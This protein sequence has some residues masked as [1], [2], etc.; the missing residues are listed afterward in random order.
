MVGSNPGP[1]TPDTR[2]ASYEHSRTFI[3]GSLISRCPEMPRP[4]GR[5]WLMLNPNIYLWSR[6]IMDDC[7]ILVC[8]VW[9]GQVV[10]LFEHVFCTSGCFYPS[11]PSQCVFCFLL[12]YQG[13]RA[14]CTVPFISSWKDNIMPIKAGKG[15]LFF[16][17]E[18]RDFLKWQ[19]E[20]LWWDH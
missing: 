5:D 20:K 8:V 1:Q 10:V 3:V 19:R 4:C 7:A 16:E 9:D 11:L 13:L 12:S 18:Q 15:V 14:N 17:G 6:D 2:Q